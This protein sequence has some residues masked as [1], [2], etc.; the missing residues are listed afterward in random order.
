[1][2]LRYVHTTG[3]F[4]VPDGAWGFSVADAGQVEPRTRDLIVVTGPEGSGKTRFL[5]AIASARELLAPSGD[6]FDEDDWVR[7]GNRS[8]K[9]V[10]GFELSSKERAEIGSA[11]RDLPAEVIFRADPDWVAPD[12]TDP[13]LLY[14]LERYDHD[15]A[16]SKLEY[17]G[18][19]RRLDVGG[20]EMSL[21][22]ER[23]HELRTGKSP[24]K[25]A[26]IPPFL[27]SLRG[28][29]LGSERFARILEALG[30]SLRWDEG[31]RLLVTRTRKLTDLATLSSSEADAL[32]FAATFCLVRLSS[33][34][35]LVDRPE[36]YRPDVERLVE[37]LRRAGDDNQLIVAS[38]HPALT[39]AAHDRVVIRLDERSPTSSSAP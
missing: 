10:L 14:L 38:T 22:R 17:F 2:K 30:D 4:G 33:S 11:E 29:A 28:D 21:G 7:E 6:R 35:V 15:P 34:I 18:E 8:A 23:Q 36:L 37:G 19:N 9:V 3:L 16:V 20:G 39:K 31:E 12:Q 5:E 32:L 24:R 13:G 27:R 1:M 25:Y 26:F